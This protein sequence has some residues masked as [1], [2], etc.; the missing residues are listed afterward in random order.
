M[1]VLAVEEGPHDV[2]DGYET[3]TVD[4]RLVPVGCLR[5]GAWFDAKVPVLS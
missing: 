1:S 3:V 2:S 4:R 5:A